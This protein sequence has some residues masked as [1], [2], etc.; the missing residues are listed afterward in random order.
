MLDGA[1][2]AS[3]VGRAY[4]AT[5]LLFLYGA[6]PTWTRE[7]L[8]S[9]FDWTRN[10]SHAEQVWDGHLSMGK[11]SDGLLTDL[12][13][14]YGWAIPHLRNLREELRNHFYGHLTDIAFLSSVH[15]LDDD[16]LAQ[17]I[18]AGSEAD[19]A[20]WARA[21]RERLKEVSEETKRAAW[22]RWLKEYWS[23]RVR[24]VPMSLSPE[25]AGYMAEWTTELGVY[26]GEVVS[27]VL[28]GPV[29]ALESDS[30][31]HRLGT[32]ELP[33]GHPDAVARLMEHVLSGEC[34]PFYA[35][36][37]A[38]AVIDRVSSAGAKPAVVRSAR[39]QLARL[40][41]T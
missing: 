40:G 27:Q 37:E 8:L 38:M 3:S 32:T 34:D 10:A 22:P 2:Y 23:Q 19:R 5:Q 1:S 25:E 30:F 28:E 15:P 21:V 36:N 6:D 13:P 20:G 11:F 7:R 14:Y 16:W 26:Y 33:Q 4:M 9:S 35:C 17:F 31:Y 18:V 39:G 29:P 24:G 12:L 41:C